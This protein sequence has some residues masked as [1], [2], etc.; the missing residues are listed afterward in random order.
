MKKVTVFETV[1]E[2]AAGIDI[3]AKKIFVSPDGLEVHLTGSKPEILSLS[4]ESNSTHKNFSTRKIDKNT[5][6][7]AEQVRNGALRGESYLQVVT[8]KGKVTVENDKMLLRKRTM[9]HYT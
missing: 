8:A 4:L 1:H 9:L 7:L 3:G 5:L 6:G 2:H